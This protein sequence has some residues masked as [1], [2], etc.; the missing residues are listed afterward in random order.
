MTIFDLV[1]STEIVAYWTALNKDKPPFLG[2]ELFPNKKQLGLK[3]EYIKGARGTPVVLKPS[4]YDVQAIPRPRLGFDKIETYMPFFK[5]SMYIDEEM[6]QT[7]N[8][9]I[10]TGNKAYIDS[11]MEKIFD[12]SVQLLDAAAVRREQMRMSL[13]TTGA[14]S[15][16]ANGQAYSYDY[17]VPEEH[18]VT[19]TVNWA[20]TSTDI[21]SDIRTWQD[22]IE[23][24]TGV[25]PTRAICSRKT[26]GYIEANLGIRGLIYIGNVSTNNP[27]SMDRVKLFMQSEL[28][29]DV[30]VYSKRYKNDA[31]AATSFIPD[32][33][34]IMLPP[35]KLGETNFGTTPE[36]SD[37]M[38]SA[39]ANVAIT[40]T[41][42]AVTTTQKADPV[43]VD[44]KVSM[45]SLP[46]FEMADHI[47]IADLVAPANGA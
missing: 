24:D 33:T 10:A 15:V 46:S 7:L 27:V 22:L 44:T 45:I 37:L 43:Q 20:T 25:R 1:K 16:A 36:E 28:G 32:D 9:A 34:F 18:K 11:I 47:I 5:E 29:L 26:M 31:G 23:D 30:T 39:A 6:R 19:V 35:D 2:E 40:D 41:G 3:I 17:G 21:I 12:D 4:A 38:T 13:L 8:L 14:I 42:V